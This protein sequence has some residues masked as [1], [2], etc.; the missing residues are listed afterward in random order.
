MG[1]AKS[2]EYCDDVLFNLRSDLVWATFS[3]RHTLSL[4]LLLENVKDAVN[5]VQFEVFIASL[6]LLVE[7]VVSAHSSGFGI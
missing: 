2:R 3:T 5:R 1:R 6:P 7:W 4:K